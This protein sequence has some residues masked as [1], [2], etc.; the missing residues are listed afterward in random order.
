[1]IQRLTNYVTFAE[2]YSKNISDTPWNLQLSLHPDPIMDSGF[3]RKDS[4]HT[5]EGDS[6]NPPRNLTVEFIHIH[7]II[8]Q[9]KVESTKVNIVKQSCHNYVTV[10]FGI[11]VLSE[12]SGGKVRCSIQESSGN[13]V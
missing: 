3:F 2:K 5:C 12:M 6:G 10:Q 8:Q 7:G 1:M 11:K 9:V 4:L 13:D